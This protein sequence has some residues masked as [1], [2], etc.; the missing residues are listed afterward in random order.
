MAGYFAVQ[1]LPRRV[2][3][4]D[5]AGIDTGMHAIPS[6]LISCSQSGPSRRGF[7]ERRELRLIHVGGEIADLC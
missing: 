3:D 4:V 1:S 5:A 6:I 7:Y 2:Q